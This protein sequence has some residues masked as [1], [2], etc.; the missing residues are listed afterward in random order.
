MPAPAEV[1]TSNSGKVSQLLIADKVCNLNLLNDI[2]RGNETR[3]HNLVLIFFSEI[4]NELSELDNAIEKTNYTV[5]TNIAHKIKSSFALLGIVVLE[6][7]IKEMEQLSI[8]T[9]FIDRIKQLS[10]KVNT[11]F[12]MARLELQIAN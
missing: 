10:Q 12:N 2:T 8:D 9:S 5:I 11:V 6:P 3:L 4:K 1:N 7:V